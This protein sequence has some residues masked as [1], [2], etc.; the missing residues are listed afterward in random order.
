M[1]SIPNQIYIITKLPLT[2]TFVL[3]ITLCDYLMLL[4]SHHGQPGSSLYKCEPFFL[5]V[6]FRLF[7]STLGSQK[8][9]KHICF[10]LKSVNIILITFICNFCCPPIRYISALVDFQHEWPIIKLGFAL[11]WIISFLHPEFILSLNRSQEFTTV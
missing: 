1:N 9:C 11:M 8:F 6:A 2:K 3:S 4:C 10:I 7:H 5:S